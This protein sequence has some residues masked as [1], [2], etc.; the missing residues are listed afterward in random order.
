MRTLLDTDCT[1]INWVRIL[2]LQNGFLLFANL[3]LILWFGSLGIIVT[4]FQDFKSLKKRISPTFSYFLI[5]NELL[6]HFLVNWLA[7][8]KKM[9]D[10][11]VFHELSFN[12]V[13]KWRRNRSQSP[14]F[15]PQRKWNLTFLVH[16]KSLSKN[17]FCYTY[18]YIGEIWSSK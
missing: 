17:I 2:A 12:Q 10:K 8:N 4:S 18:Q 1:K 16:Q 6:Y 11:S 13:L 7:H 3:L 14:V 15:V 5:N 9:T